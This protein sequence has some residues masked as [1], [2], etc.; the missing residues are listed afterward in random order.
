M[1]PIADKQIT[2]NVKNANEYYESALINLRHLGEKVITRGKTM[3]ELTNVVATVTNPRDRLLTEVNR[4]WP[5]KGF[6]A[7]VLWYL[8]G[9]PTLRT[10]TKYLPVWAQ[11]SDNGSTV[12][13]NYGNHWFPYVSN[14]IEILRKDPGARHACFSIY[15]SHYS[16]IQTKDVPCTFAIQFLIRDNRL[17]MIVFNRSRDVIKGELG[18]DFYAFSILQELVANELEVEIG[19]YTAM[20]GSLH[21]YEQD[22]YKMFETLNFADKI[23]YYPFA[24]NEKIKFKY[25]N[26]LKEIHAACNK[27]I[28][29]FTYAN[30]FLCDI[31]LAKQIDVADFVYDL[32]QLQAKD[33]PTF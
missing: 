3:I 23:D 21:I 25:T 27:S 17:N 4:K 5:I 32:D 10:I 29:D 20:H 18:G 22:F 16:M 15:K 2:I 12:N 6:T 19:T 33:L 11:F 13:S 24:Y 14:I 31:I 1:N 8:S 9:N 30:D 26:A 7:E 28:N